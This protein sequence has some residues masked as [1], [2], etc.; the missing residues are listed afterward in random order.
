[1]EEFLSKHAASSSHGGASLFVCGESF[2]GGASQSVRDCCSHGVQM[3]PIRIVLRTRLA[4]GASQLVVLVFLSSLLVRPML[5]SLA[6]KRSWNEH[7][8][9]TV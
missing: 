5:F 7:R 3:N 8:N 1:M 2:Q 9:R 4:R 6:K